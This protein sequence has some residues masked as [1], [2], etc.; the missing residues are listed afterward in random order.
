MIKRNILTI[1][2]PALFFLLLV[3]CEARA[4]LN[5]DS[6]KHRISVGLDFSLEEGMKQYP[7]IKAR[8]HPPNLYGIPENNYIS[9]GGWVGIGINSGIMVTNH[10]QFKLG[11]RWEV[12]PQGT[13]FAE[14]DTVVTFS[15][16]NITSSVRYFMPIGRQSV[17]RWFVGGG[18]LIGVQ[19]SMKEHSQATPFHP[20]PTAYSAEIKY[21]TAIGST[22]ETGIEIYLKHPRII[23]NGGLGFHIINYNA[24]SYSEN[25]KELSLDKLPTDFNLRRIEGS[26]GGLNFAIKYLF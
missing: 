18:L 7:G 17:V 8:Y 20:Q 19:P 13:I 14:H 9:P 6:L 26:G 12:A 16:F 15:K 4:Q 3:V 11:V 5:L 24:R 1:L 23:L 22:I 25:N 21:N 2:A 10:L